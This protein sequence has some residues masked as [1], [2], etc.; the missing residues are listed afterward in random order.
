MLRDG[1]AIAHQM[2]QHK[3]LRFGR[4]LTNMLRVRGRE[5]R[6]PDVHLRS[7]SL[8]PMIAKKKAKAKKPVSKAAA[9]PKAAKKTKKK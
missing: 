8:M 1:V 4:K 7:H 3:V 9:K 6:Y 2:S 5:V